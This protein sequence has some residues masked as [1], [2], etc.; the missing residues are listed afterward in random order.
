MPDEDLLPPKAGTGADDLPAVGARIETWRVPEAWRLPPRMEP[1]RPCTGWVP[2]A[3]AAGA[4]AEA[5]LSPPKS[6][7]KKPGPEDAATTGAATGTAAGGAGARAGADLSPPKNLAKKPGPE[8][9]A[10]VGAAA[11]RGVGA[12]RGTG[13]GRTDLTGTREAALMQTLV[14]CQAYAITKDRIYSH[15]NT[16]NL[17]TRQ[18]SRV[19]HARESPNQEPTENQ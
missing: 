15:L 16:K 4:G 9:A 10:A 18:H 19:R 11:A 17:F 7:K 13:A 8:G 2:M 5:D 12:A 14:D 3:R 6:F 1:W